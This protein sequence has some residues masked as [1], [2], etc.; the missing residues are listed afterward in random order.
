MNFPPGLNTVPPG[1][2]RVGSEPRRLIQTELVD[3]WGFV[4][5][6]SEPVTWWAPR[7]VI[8]GVTEWFLFVLNPA[9]VSTVLSGSDF[10]ARSSSSSKGSRGR[11]AGGF[12]FGSP[13]RDVTCVDQSGSGLILVACSWVTRVERGD[14]SR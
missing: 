6:F 14:L 3:Y 2:K 1:R 11:S 4:G 13:P 7:R 5:I 12:V 10:P 9:R 8:S